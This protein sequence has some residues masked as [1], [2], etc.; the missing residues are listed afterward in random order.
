MLSVDTI[1]EKIIVEE[2][3]YRVYILSFYNGV[4]VH[5][6]FCIQKTSYTSHNRVACLAA[7]I[8][9]QSRASRSSDNAGNVLSQNGE[10]TLDVG[11]ADRAGDLG[12]G[13]G[14]LALVVSRLADFA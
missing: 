12:D 1:I 9:G 13:V 6:H 14:V 5:A 8:L 3:K 10:L 2:V 7:S 4:N 11:V